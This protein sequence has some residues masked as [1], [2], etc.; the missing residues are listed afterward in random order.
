ML[1][2]LYYKPW[3][4][5]KYCILSLIL[6]IDME[7][8]VTTQCKSWHFCLC[9][10]HF[11]CQFPFVSSPYHSINIPFCGKWKV[12]GPTRGGHSIFLINEV[13]TLGHRLGCSRVWV[14]QEVLVL[15]TVT[16]SGYRVYGCSCLRRTSISVRFT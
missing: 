1:S 13:Y 14:F 12:Q 6:W 4:I 16:S 7:K 11:P 15:L 5:E 2:H 9:L 8:N 3:E 10:G